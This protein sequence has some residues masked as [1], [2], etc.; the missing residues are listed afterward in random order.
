MTS[1]IN[2]MV[3][4]PSVVLKEIGERVA[5][6]RLQQNI[7]QDDLAQKAG[8]AVRTLRRLEAG[9]GGSLETLVRLLQGLDQADSLDLV[10]PRVHISPMQAIKASSKAG[11][12]MSRVRA[13][14]KHIKPKTSWTWDEKET[15]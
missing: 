12:D 6:N 13:R 7:T 1:K 14:K 11:K 3:A 2:F 9:S 4:P 10:L 8:V 15:P 5:E